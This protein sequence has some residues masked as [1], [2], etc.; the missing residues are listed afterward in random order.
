MRAAKLAGRV[1]GHNQFCAER[2][3]DWAPGGQ[4]RR[5][6]VSSV[7]LSTSGALGVA[8]AG[9]YNDGGLPWSLCLGRERAEI[10]ARER[11]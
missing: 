3:S 6:K 8:D 9:N 2:N 10:P 7:A 4:L 1:G 11:F 5:G